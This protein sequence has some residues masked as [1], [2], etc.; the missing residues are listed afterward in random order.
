MSRSEARQNAA[1]GQATVLVVDDDTDTVAT[2]S[3][4]LHSKQYAVLSSNSGEEALEMASRQR[5]DVVLLDVSLND[6]D[7]ITVAGRLR[8]DRR[9]AGLPIIF[10]TGHKESRYKIA[11][12]EAGAD[13]YVTKP[14]DF[15]EVETRLR[16][17]LK[18]KDLRDELE[19]TNR[20]LR[21]ANRALKKL[22]ITDEKTQLYNYR[23]LRERIGEEFKRAVRYDNPLSCIMLDLDHFKDI[24][25][26]LGHRIGDRVLEE[27]GVILTDSARETDL[28]VRYGGEEFIIILPHTST[29]QA[30]TVAERIR[31]S[32]M[33]RTFTVDEAP[34]KLTVSCGVS[35]YPANPAIR[36]DEDLVR[37]AD[38]AL[39]EAKEAGR[40]RTV[41]DSASLQGRAAHHRSRRRNQAQAE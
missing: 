14:L 3:R 35:T 23:F 25:D 17:V 39:Y 31:R 40:N 10:V 15:L 5:P 28:V 9:T 1:G 11:C 21:R 24:N 4:W 16:A 41:A 13:D 33:R 36:N 27:F 20:A 22:L 32:T 29:R 2:L 30:M 26:T 38:R 7:G 37:T 6:I 34:L 19:R 18:K 8:A 12:F